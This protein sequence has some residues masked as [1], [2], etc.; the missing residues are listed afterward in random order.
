MTLGIDRVDPDA[1]NVNQVRQEFRRSVAIA[2][3]FVALLWI[4]LIVDV[5]VDFPLPSLGVRPHA[6]GG[7][8]GLLTMPLL[9]GGPAHLIHNSL[10]GL[11][12]L[13]SLLFFYPKSSLRVLPWMWIV[14]GLFVWVVGDAGS[15]HFGASGLNFALLGYV[16][17]GGLLRKSAP[18]L[19]LSL[20][21][22]FLWGGMLSGILPME[23][24]ISW[25]G[26]LGGL[27]TGLFLAVVF[28]RWDIPPAKRYDWEDEELD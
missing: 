21:T 26:H 9:H 22:L 16:G 19:A 27:I 6:A 8:V 28:R 24:G 18:P 20:V 3:S 10:P 13:A 23:E 7:L 5:V 4:I 17:L 15:T 12:M 25:E 14:P 1:V 2:L 11:T